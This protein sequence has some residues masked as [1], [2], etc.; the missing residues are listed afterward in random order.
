MVCMYKTLQHMQQEDETNEQVKNDSKIT[1][2][3]KKYQ[4]RIIFSNNS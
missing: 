4:T 2:F 3:G 1:T